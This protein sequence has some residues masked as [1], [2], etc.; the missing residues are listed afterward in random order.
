[1][2]CEPCASLEVFPKGL[3]LYSMLRRSLQSPPNFNLRGLVAG[4]YSHDRS[5]TNFRCG[6]DRPNATKNN[7]C[8]GLHPLLV[9]CMEALK[10]RSDW[11]GDAARLSGSFAPHEP[12]FDTYHGSYDPPHLSRSLESESLPSRRNQILMLSPTRSHESRLCDTPIRFHSCC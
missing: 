1:M 10:S 9:D 3:L 6:R 2:I 8:V 11:E 5:H 4:L 12:M 7:D